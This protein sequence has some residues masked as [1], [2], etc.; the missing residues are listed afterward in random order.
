MPR[1][2]SDRAS[3]PTESVSASDSSAEKSRRGFLKGSVG[4]VAG[5]AAAQLLPSQVA[6]QQRGAASGLNRLTSANG[7]PILLKDGMVL[8]M[9]RQVGDFEKGEANGAAASLTLVHVVA[10]AWLLSRR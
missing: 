6:A 1:K 8:S 2:D 7:R 5:A 4:L 9:D 10:D 3:E